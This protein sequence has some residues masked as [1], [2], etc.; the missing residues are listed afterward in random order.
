M[1]V[2]QYSIFLISLDPTTGHEINKTRPC[3]IVSPDEINDNIGTVIIAPMTTGSFIYPTRVQVNFDGK[4]GL[5]VLDQIKTVDKRRLVKK[6]GSL[7]QETI[8]KVKN[9]LK[10]ML[11]D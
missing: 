4:K 9:I 10:E 7:D 3:L 5:I 11:V 2:K 8:V 6:L 1:V